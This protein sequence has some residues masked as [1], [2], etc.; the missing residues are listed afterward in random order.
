MYQLTEQ[1]DSYLEF[2]DANTTVLV[3]ASTAIIVS[4]ENNVSILKTAAC[5]KN[6]LMFEEE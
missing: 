2:Q 5:R 4:E 3:P 6:I 1:T